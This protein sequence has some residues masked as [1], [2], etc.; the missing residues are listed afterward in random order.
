M[1]ANG[2]MYIDPTVTVPTVYPS[3]SSSEE[4]VDD[5]FG[6]VKD[7]QCT[8]CL[9]QCTAERYLSQ[10]TDSRKKKGWCKAKAATSRTKT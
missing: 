3:E 1:D 5:G 9:L 7:H 6:P 10:H 2:V 8:W 4:S